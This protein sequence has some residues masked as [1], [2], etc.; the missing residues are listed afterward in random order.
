MRR[1]WEPVQNELVPSVQIPRT[2]V[3]TVS[4]PTFTT[5]LRPAS[6]PGQKQN[7]RKRRTHF[8]S[9]PNLERT[10]PDRNNWNRAFGMVRICI[11]GSPKSSSRLTISRHQHP[12]FEET[13]EGGSF[14]GSYQVLFCTQHSHIL[15]SAKKKIILYFTVLS[16]VLKAFYQYFQVSFIILNNTRKQFG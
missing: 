14:S 13:A 16:P 7:T 1:C 10:G 3:P 12:V 9:L 6:Q 4:R 5:W 15:K 11:S 2:N 8:C